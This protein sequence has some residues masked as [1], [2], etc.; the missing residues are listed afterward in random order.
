MICPNKIN[1]NCMSTTCYHSVSHEP[2]PSCKQKAAI[3]GCPE[4][5]I[6]TIPEVEKE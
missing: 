6:E 3:K 4:K 1:N 5:C 2:M